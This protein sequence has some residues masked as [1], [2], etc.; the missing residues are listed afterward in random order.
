MTVVVIVAVAVVVH[1]QALVQA[2]GPED[3]GA[4]ISIV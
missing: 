1:V 2:R 4:R 3:S